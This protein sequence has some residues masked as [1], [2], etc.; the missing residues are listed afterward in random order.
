MNTVIINGKSMSV[1]GNNISV[2][3]DKVY[4][5][6]KLVEEGLSGNVTISFEGDLASLK[7]SGSATIHGN[8][9]GDVDAGG[10]VK[11]GNVSKSVDAGGSV[12]CLNVG[13]DVDAG[14]SVSMK[15]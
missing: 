10:S 9:M 4:V 11:C 7:T 14:G 1:V 15:R 13:G 2:I 5:D 12:T 8:V 6:G 3:N